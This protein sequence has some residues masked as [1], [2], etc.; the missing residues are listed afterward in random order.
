MASSV[1]HWATTLVE[2]WS[3]WLPSHPEYA[4]GID[5]WMGSETQRQTAASTYGIDTLDLGGDRTFHIP[6]RVDLGF[7]MPGTLTFSVSVGDANN[8]SVI[9]GAHTLVHT[10]SSYIGVNRL[11]VRK[12]WK[13]GVPVRF[14]I[15]ASTPAGQLR[16]GVLVHAYMRRVR[17]VSDTT[18][19]GVR[20]YHWLADTV[21]AR[22]LTSDSVPVSLTFT[23]RTVD[24]FD[25]LLEATDA[26]GRPT[27]TSIHGIVDGARGQYVPP[28]QSSA[29]KITTKSPLPA[30][31]GD[32]VV[33]SFS[34]PFDNADA[35]LTLEREGVLSQ[36]RISVGSGNTSVR[37]PIV[38]RHEP[39][40]VVAVTLVRRITGSTADDSLSDDLRTGSLNVP[41]DVSARRLF[42]AI[43]PARASY[44]PGDTAT[45]RIQ[46]R[47]RDSLSGG[48][49]AAE[50]AVWAVDEGVLSLTGFQTPNPFFAFTAPE[51]SNTALR[52][53]FGSFTWGMLT[54]ESLVEGGPERRIGYDMGGRGLLLGA[55]T[56][57]VSGTKAPFSVSMLQTNLLPLRQA[58][59]TTAFFIGSVKTN[60][61]GAAAIHVTLPDN[62]STFRIMAVAST[63]D[64]RYGNGQTPLLTT[65]DLVVRAA[66]PRFVR[67]GD[68]LTAGG[69]VNVRSGATDRVSVT[70][71]AINALINGDS[72]QTVDARDGRATRARFNFRV[73]ADATAA[74][75][76]ELRGIGELGNDAVATT[77]ALAPVGTP[78]THSVAGVL[79]D[80]TTV[81]LDLPAGIDKSRSTISIGFGSSPLAAIRND[82]ARLRAYP[83]YATECI[84]STGR[85]LIALQHAEATLGEP[86]EGMDS[87]TVRTD[88]Q[89]AVDVILH[90]EHDGWIYE[91]DDTP[92]IIGPWENAYA[93]DLLI[94][95][96]EHGAHVS[97][98]GLARIVDRTRSWMH[99]ARNYPDTVSGSPFERRTHWQAWIGERV[100]QARFVRRAGEPDTLVEQDLFA[101]VDELRWEDRVSL[102]GLLADAGR[103]AEARQ[104]IDRLWSVVGAIGGRVEIPDSLRAFGVFPSHIRPAARLLI[105]TTR[106]DPD[107]ALT[108][109][110]VETI[111][112]QGRAERG[113]AWNTQD[114]A[115]AAV[116]LTGFAE[117][118]HA[119]GSRRVTVTGYDGRRLLTGSTAKSSS[120]TAHLERLLARRSADSSRLDLRISGDGDAGSPIFFAVNVVEVPTARPVT[121]DVTGIVVERW[122][123]RFK[124][125]KPIIEATEGDLVRVRLRVTVPADRQF[126]VL[127]DL[128]PAGLE[129]VDLS[130]RTEGVGPFATTAFAQ[131]EQ[132][133][134]DSGP[135][136]QTL[137]YGGWDSGWW[138]PWE[139]KEIHDDRVTWTARQLWSGTYTASYVARA[140]TPGTFV[141][142]PAHAEEMYNQAVKG[143]SDGGSFTVS[144]KGS[145]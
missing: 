111:V 65:R 74:V 46:V 133:R 105:E 102:A 141:R 128:L 99:D 82:Y 84:A 87:A 90:R 138:T 18:P 134:G 75:H 121:P 104:S 42:V 98:A 94:D 60:G 20:N 77:I 142:P 7:R 50:V 124:D 19:A 34:S 39:N 1:V 100:V 67:P 59:R 68:D 36:R 27:A 132:R 28:R 61:T 107:R 56:G 8:Q 45:V 136:L 91:W 79:R 48:G 3:A 52:T 10:V 130:L 95:A 83:Y 25:L 23:P 29:L 114:Y 71:S 16:R 49:V 76:L 127:E 31:V 81:H 11:A 116:A 145:N 53:S 110:L 85:A 37:I 120:T 113:W 57:P 112:Q 14:D 21:E 38:R 123:E 103:D 78:R 64:D 135:L 17:W 106:L 144:A 88:L 115:A 70:A 139:H 12:P 9:A 24:H 30:Q 32:T 4:I 72:I 92:F 96:R 125:G 86:S 6:T 44:R 35:W 97:G 109:A 126:V 137:V 58:F 129:P 62:I 63:T 54:R 101:R 140:T 43:D 118:Q 89:H 131:Q 47:E 40:V 5:Q 80:S 117:R 2:N 51:P 41:V 55:L 69:V 119:A 13:V 15:I 108:G 26:E 122:Y 66:F 143:R 33:V 73:P 22:Q 93:G